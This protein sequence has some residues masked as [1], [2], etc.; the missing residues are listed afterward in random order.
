MLRITE[1]YLR[2]IKLKLADLPVLENALIEHL[3]RHLHRLYLVGSQVPGLKKE[4]LSPVDRAV[5]THRRVLLALRVLGFVSTDDLNHRIKHSLRYLFLTLRL[6]LKQ[7]T[8]G[9]LRVLR[10]ESPA[11]LQ[12]HMDHVVTRVHDANIKLIPQTKI[13]RLPFRLQFF[14]HCHLPEIFK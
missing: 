2:D 8:G 5:I 1:V 4:M 10:L 13:R 9:F 14:R 3:Q 11:T 12:K 7:I 6:L